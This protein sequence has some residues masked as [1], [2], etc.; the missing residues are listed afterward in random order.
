MPRPTVLA[1]T[2]NVTVASW[3]NLCIAIVR[4]ELRIED[5]EAVR[6]TY[7]A[8]AAEK[9][10][11]FV[12]VIVA[13]PNV[14]M[15]SEE[16]RKIIPDIMR[17]IE[18]RMLAMVGVLESTGFKA[19]AVRSAMAV[20][21]MLARTSYPRKIAASIHEVA[22]WISGHVQPAATREQIEE[23]VEEAKKL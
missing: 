19:A 8:F 18:D 7:Q 15:P 20:M 2:Q 16:A 6:R 21:S 14:G 5:V 10:K 4:D 13:M 1:R 17:G 11:G 9:D 3:S 12:S 22:P 23:A